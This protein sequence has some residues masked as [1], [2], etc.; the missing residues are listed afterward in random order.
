MTEEQKGLVY[1]LSAY[2]LWGFFPLYW[3]LLEHVDSLEILINRMIWSFVFTFLF[4][5]IIKQ[6]KDLVADLKAIWKDKKLFFSLML[7]SI[8][9]TINWYMYIWAVNHDHVV[10]T[11]LGYYINPILTVIFGVIFF[12][13]KLSK[14]QI[15]AVIIAFT[16]VLIMTVS[17]GQV[18]WIAILIALSFAT[19]SALKKGIKLDATRGL[20]IETLFITPFAL[21]YYIYLWNTQETSFLQVNF[22]TDLVLILGGIV[23]AIPLVL[24]AKGAQKI[25]QYLIGFTQYITPTVV[26]ILG[27]VLYNESFTTID[28][29]SFSFI[30]LAILLFI[31][32]TITDYRKRHHAKHHPINVN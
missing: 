25:P 23:T 8:V 26:L 16:G 19:Y 24:F 15:A 17:Y 11:S 1:A 22:T 4:I 7:A 10:D 9:I 21:G 29:I 32:S 13:E 14:A 27:I 31:A 12:K 18:P 2:G 3:K 28:F 20:A 5:F 30:W 6:R